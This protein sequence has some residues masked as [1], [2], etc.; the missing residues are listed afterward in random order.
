MEKDIYVVVA[1]FEVRKDNSDHMESRPIVFETRTDTATRENAQQFIERLNGN[2]GDCRIAKLQFEDT[3]NDCRELLIRC[4]D[5]FNSI[6]N[7][8]INDGNRGSTYRLASEIE[9]FL[10]LQQE[11]VTEKD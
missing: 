5:A 10:N 6:P 9:K 2:Y 11:H 3:G 8:K 4:L 1:E 7:Q